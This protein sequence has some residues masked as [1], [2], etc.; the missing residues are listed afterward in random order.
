MLLLA[1]G[2][3]SFQAQQPAP[4]ASVYTGHTYKD[5]TPNSIRG[6]QYRVQQ[7]DTLYSIAFASGKDF[8]SLAQYNSLRSPY[9]IFPG[10]TLTLVKPDQKKIA[11]RSPSQATVTASKP[12]QPKASTAKTANSAQ[13]N[14]Q[15]TAIDPTS[16]PRYAGS[17]SSQVDNK[18]SSV[19]TAASPSLPKQV[20]RWHWPTNGRVIRGFSSAE[21][22]NKGLDIAAAEGTPVVSAA[23]GRVVYAGSALRGYGKLIIIKH[24]DDFL[25]AYAHNRRIL[26]KEKQQVEAGQKIAE[27]GNTDADRHMLHFE[28][29]HRGKSVD[30]MR[31]LPQR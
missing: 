30:P 20:S 4:V 9:T 23:P 14:R 19:K 12:S 16:Q 6:S 18:T 1:L 22:G 21:Q 17:E 15:K 24:N 10:Q 29:R 8:R 13:Q 11:V 3:C 7:G 26:V 5:R 25:S 2:G 31:Y 28:I 27:V